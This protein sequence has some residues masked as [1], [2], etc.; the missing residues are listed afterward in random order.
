MPRLPALALSLTLTTLV[1]AQRRVHVV[2]S[3]AP[4]AH[5][6]VESAVS[7]AADGDIVY[8]AKLSTPQTV[9]ISGKGLYL[10][11]SP[12]AA[13]MVWVVK[14]ELARSTQQARIHGVKTATC[15]F[16][17]RGPGRFL[18]ESSYAGRLYCWNAESIV[19]RDVRVEPPRTAHDPCSLAF[20][21][22]KLVSLQGC[23]TGGGAGSFEYWTW[24]F[25]PS[26][27]SA[28]RGGPAVIV[29]G[30]RLEIQACS[31][32]G[33]QGGTLCWFLGSTANYEYGRGGP[34]LRLSNCKARVHGD[35]LQDRISAGGGCER[36]AD[37]D[38]RD[39]SELV[40]SG[41][42]LVV[43]ASGNSTYKSENALGPYLES[44]SFLLGRG[45]SVSIR[46]MPSRPVLT[47]SASRLHTTLYSF[48]PVYL[49]LGQLWFAHPSV[50]DA[51]GRG[52][53]QIPFGSDP[54]MLGQQLYLQCFL[55]M[56]GGVHSSGVTGGTVH[57]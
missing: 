16:E 55:F 46:G 35:W 1:G 12:E 26:A 36:V 39:S 29:E 51:G 23:S 49:D 11:V 9:I 52:S 22:C 27:C 3:F 53:F 56:P 42:P 5:R 30:G 37:I 41:L 18:I 48:G 14:W 10:F 40:F 32:G 45:S 15:S 20:Q 6:A 57:L 2:D 7:A 38:L 43:S 21:G 31:F 50:L 25:P 17:L 28:E 24:P 33:G 4:G 54:M 8:L 34:A 13:S 19:L 44:K 47:L